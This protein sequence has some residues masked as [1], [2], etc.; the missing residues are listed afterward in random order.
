MKIFYHATSK[1]NLGSILYNGLIA[2][3]Q[4]CIFMTEKEED[5]IKFLALRLI[6]EIVTIKIRVYKE[7]YDKIQ[8][9][10][11]HD[12]SFFK[13]KAFGYFGN[14]PAENIEA[15]KIYTNP[16]VM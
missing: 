4:G 16:F 2:G 14:I 15:C 12:P 9:T 1:D 10:F 8:E 13:C 5:A 11:D 7:D 3:S 6:P